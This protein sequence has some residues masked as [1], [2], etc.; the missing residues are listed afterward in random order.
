MNVNWE[1]NLAELIE[2]LKPFVS[3]GTITGIFLGD[4]LV[5]QGVFVECAVSICSRCCRVGTVGAMW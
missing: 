3:N 1:A 5:D 4:E 2:A